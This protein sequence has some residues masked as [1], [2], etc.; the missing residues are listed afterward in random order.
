[1][2]NDDMSY[3][4]SLCQ[5]FRKCL[6]QA[7]EKEQEREQ[8]KDKEQ[9]QEQ[10]QEQDEKS[11]DTEAWNPVEKLTL[12]KLLHGLL[13][14]REVIKELSTWTKFETWT[15]WYIIAIL[16]LAWLNL[17]RR[18]LVFGNHINIVDTPSDLLLSLGEGHYCTEERC[19]AFEVRSA[20][21]TQILPFQAI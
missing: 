16:C 4:W 14:S 12:L 7:Q 11:L 20:W 18:F 6:A 21:E 2:F 13:A 8:E 15:M 10:E 19:T 1:M 17:S 9:E 3:V 5:I